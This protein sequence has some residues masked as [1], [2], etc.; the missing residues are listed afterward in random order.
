M[1]SVGLIFSLN[2]IFCNIFKAVGY[3]LMGVICFLISCSPGERVYAIMLDGLLSGDGDLM[4][5]VLTVN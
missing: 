4:G 5:L 3:Y 1:R 2:S